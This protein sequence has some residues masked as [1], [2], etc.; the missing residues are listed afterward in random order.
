VAGAAPAT[1]AAVPINRHRDLA[2]H[3]VKLAL[4]RKDVWKSEEFF[5][6]TG[7]LSGRQARTQIVLPIAAISVGMFVFGLVYY[8]DVPHP[9]HLRQRGYA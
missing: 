3:Q 5:T 1:A 8:L 7:N 6:S 2:G 9:V 4:A